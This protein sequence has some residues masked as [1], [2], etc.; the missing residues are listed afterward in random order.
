[1]TEADIDGHVQGGRPVVVGPVQV[2][3]MLHQ[4][5]D[6]CRMVMGEAHAA[7]APR[8]GPVQGGI[9]LPVRQGRVPA[10]FEH[11]RQVLNRPL[12]RGHVN[13]GPAQ[14]GKLHRHVRVD[15]V[16]QQ[17][18]D[19]V[20][21]IIVVAGHVEQPLLIHRDGPGRAGGQQEQAD[22]QDQ[23]PGER[24]AGDGT[25]RSQALHD[26]DSFRDDGMVWRVVGSF[27][28]LFLIRFT[29]TQ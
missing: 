21:P 13:G 15:S 17:G 9:P 7:P 4:E 10:R 19:R 12:L 22:A 27:S 2:R 8:A 6:G 5:P 1:M 23:R 14:G 3:P 16:C 24:E 11:G 25:E 28:V 26:A 29:C 18:P 20:V